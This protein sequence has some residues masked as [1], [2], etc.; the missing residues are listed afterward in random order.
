[1]PNN[2]WKSFLAARALR[3]RNAKTFSRRWLAKVA[4]C[5]FYALHFSRSLVG[6][7]V[8]HLVNKIPLATECFKD[9]KICFTQRGAQLDKLSRNE[10]PRK[11]EKTQRTDRQTNRHF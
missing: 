9:I 5:P 4:Y 3:I 8:E 10:K 6:G 1:M 2:N 7:S 11:S